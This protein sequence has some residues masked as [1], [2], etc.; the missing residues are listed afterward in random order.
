[1][2]NNYINAPEAAAAEEMQL[3]QVLRICWQQLRDHW[4]W[5]LFSVCVALAAGFLYQQS[6]PRVY[7]RQ[8]V[9]LI[10]DGQDGGASAGSRSVRR[11]GSTM[12]D[13]S[14]ISVGQN[15]KNELFIL[16]SHRL[17]EHVV[18][19]LHL[20]VDYTAK[21]RLRT[22][23]LYQNR[24]VTVEFLDPLRSRRAMALTLRPAQGGKVEL[25]GFT[26]N[27]V[28]SQ[29]RL[30]APLG[31]IVSTPAGRLRLLRAPGWNKFREMGEVSVRRYTTAQA[32]AMYCARLAVV[33]YDEES[34]LISLTMRDMSQKRAEDV[35]TEIFQAYKR[36]VVENKNRVA[37]N[38][39]EFIN[40]RISLI[41]EDL[42]SEENKLADFK[43]NNQIVDFQA[44]T[45]AYLSESSAARRKSLDAAT[46]LQVAQYLSEFIQGHAGRGDVIPTMELQNSTVNSLIAQCNAKM[47]ERAR[48]VENTGESSYTVREADR[49]INSLRQSVASSLQGYIGTLRLALENAQGTERQL[50]SQLGGVPEKEKMALDIQR[51]QNLKEALYTY[52]LN[53]REEV[54]LQLAIGEANVRMVEAPMG[55][56]APVSPRRMVI[57]LLSLLLGLA[58]PALVLWLR[59][60][61]DVAV[62]GR[63]DVEQATSLPVTAELPH[64]KGTGSGSLITEC[65]GD[66]PVV[67][68]FRVLRHN[69]T[70]L[71]SDNKKVVLFTSTTPGQGKS[72]VSRN[73][74]A[75]YG[76]AGRRVLLI[77]ADLRKRTLSTRFHRTYALTGYLAASPV[78]DLTLDNLV[79]RDALAPG[80]DFIPAGMM[81]PNPAELLMSPRLETLIEQARQAY[82]L[83]FIDS[84]PLFAV[85]DAS[86]VSRV[87]DITLYVIRAGVQERDFLPE[88]ERLRQS[89]QLPHLCCVVNDCDRQKASGYG[90]GY[91]YGQLGADEQ[92][93]RR[94]LFRRRK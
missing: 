5:F 37:R 58:L 19:N 69:F 88:L 42:R 77:D 3:S 78:D 89:G 94:G 67:E 7:Q 65:E 30:V 11:S 18:A 53:K 43:R 26:Q 68:A 86:I 70:F 44:N 56:M 28:V 33:E 81:P 76:M 84:T 74:A 2:E 90:Y 45:Q 47:V 66:E 51:Q 63:A 4:K 38:T 54:E 29:R 64:W 79:A 75:A 46:E 22:I 20:D 62:R 91:G 73:L 93:K 57:M 35:L 92:P 82:D 55:P 41:G 12:L 52:L 24:P 15:L 25:S 49:E 32:A 1:M 60:M 83:V 23:S 80:V 48:L 72:F 40:D 61:L 31:S 9:M 39:A 13:L 6:Q 85:A 17:M 14:G 36:D 59:A 21:S 27:G 16:S 8:A 50:A 10:E 87:A 34:S 71:L